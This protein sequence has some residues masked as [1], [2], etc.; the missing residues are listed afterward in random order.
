MAAAAAIALAAILVYSNTFESPFHF[1]DPPHI[2]ERPQIRTLWPPTVAMSQSTRP[3]VAY[4][5][6][7][8]YAVHGLNVWG[9]HAVN[10]A[11]HITAGLLLFGIVR[12]SLSRVGGSF[13]E[14]AGSL[15]LV[16]ALIWLVHPLQTQA[17]TYICQRMESLMGAA[18]LATLYCFVRAQ[19]SGRPTYWYAASVASCTFGMG[20][21]EVMA[22]APLIVLWY[23]R[24]FLAGSWREVVARRKVYYLCLAAIW[25]VAVLFA[26]HYLHS[27]TSRGDLVVVEGLTPW[28]YLVSQAGVI[29]HYLRLCFWPQGQCLDY[30]WPAAHRIQDV[31]PQAILVIAMLGATVWCVFRHPKCSFLGGWFFLILAP[32]SSVV[33]IKDLAFEHRMYLPSAAVVV[34]SVVLGFRLATVLLDRVRLSSTLRRTAW[35]VV[36]VVPILVLGYTAHLRNEVYASEIT[37]WTDVV[38]KAPLWSRGWCNLGAAM[39]DQGDYPSALHCLHRALHDDPGDP[40]GNVNLGHALRDLGRYAEAVEHYEQARKRRPN[41][42]DTLVSLAGALV[43]LGRLDEAAQ[44]CQTVLKRHPDSSKAHVNLGFT[45]LAQG[46]AAEALSHFQEALRI[47]SRSAEAHAGIAQVL[48]GRDPKGALDHMAQALRLKPSSPNMNLGMGN[49]IAKT[50][51]NRAIPYFETALKVHPEYPEALFNLANAWVACG[52]PEKAIVYLE[53]AVK[54]TPDWAEAKNNLRI[55][56]QVVGAGAS[57]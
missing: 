19:D 41:D 47:D 44:L 2:G 34:G 17:V 48:S 52:H 6:A 18:Y 10:L 56:R 13:Q 36:A 25:G 45:L 1:D 54:L 28:T 38:N 30:G 27:Y 16:A 24:T 5:F 22:G 9:Y 55:L 11:I 43:P 26:F 39:I 23:D 8:N 15:A 42:D 20:C 49:L 3:V 37:L 4:S 7:V 32:T 57:R 21:K 29:T 12:R 31:L 46:L 33:P 40:E 35:I 14:H 50:D 51:P 53:T